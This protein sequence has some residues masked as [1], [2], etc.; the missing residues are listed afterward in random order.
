MFP[1]ILLCIRP[2]SLEPTT[3]TT[4]KQVEL[5][6]GPYK[7]D[8]RYD[9]TCLDQPPHP[10]PRTLVDEWINRRRRVS[11]E[12]IRPKKMNMWIERV[13][14]YCLV[15]SVLPSKAAFCRSLERCIISTHEHIYDSVSTHSTTYAI[16]ECLVAADR[17]IAR[18]FAP[19]YICPFFFF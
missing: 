19:R 16:M 14:D 7:L 9:T 13:S 1:T 11:K 12:H 8:P 18:R 15:R 6:G 5:A 3:T 10:P 4:I 2:F 17:N